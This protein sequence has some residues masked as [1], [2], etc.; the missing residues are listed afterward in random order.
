[1]DLTAEAIRDETGFTLWMS[2]PNWQTDGGVSFVE[3][4]DHQAALADQVGPENVL[5]TFYVKAGELVYGVF[6]RHREI[7]DGELAQRSLPHARAA[8]E[9]GG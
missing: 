6:V 8:L 9:G 7:I 3:S 5:G 2:L 4:G 1:M